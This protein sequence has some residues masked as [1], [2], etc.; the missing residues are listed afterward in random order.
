M[1]A[2]NSHRDS[3]CARKDQSIYDYLITFLIVPFILC[4]LSTL[5]LKRGPTGGHAPPP[6]RVF[7]ARQSY[8][9]VTGA[10]FLPDPPSPLLRLRDLICFLDDEFAFLIHDFPFLLLP[11]LLPHSYDLS[12]SME[13][14]V[15]L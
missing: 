13:E 15:R 7:V 4:L 14:A 3:H 2:L 6:P 9:S 1:I 8:P 5:A 11:S 12:Q 10:S